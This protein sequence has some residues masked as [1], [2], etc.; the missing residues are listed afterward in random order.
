MTGDYGAHINSLYGSTTERMHSLIL[1]EK[2]HIVA[3][4]CFPSK[5][6]KRVEISEDK[7]PMPY[8]DFCFEFHNY[9]YVEEQFILTEELYDTNVA[10]LE[11]IN[12][13]TML[14]DMLTENNV[15][16]YLETLSDGEA[17][18]I[19]LMY[20]SWEVGVDYKTN[21]RVE[22]DNLLWKCRQTHKSQENW[23]PSIDTASLWEVIEVQHTGTIDDPIPYINTMTVYRD[24]YYLENDVL[25]KCIR[26]SVQPL[27]ASCES[28]LGNYFEKV[29]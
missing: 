24:K 28:L 17:A 19:P 10:L 6:Q 4:D 2:S 25:Y 27:Y 3:I 22:Y 12:Q 8:E 20:P 11:K 29:S 7:F 9:S 23:K 26:D 14:I 15:Q 1:N 16:T 13:Q 5:K 18:T 21:D